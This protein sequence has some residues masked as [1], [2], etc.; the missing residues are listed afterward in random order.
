METLPAFDIPTI[1]SPPCA[2]L[3]APLP[4]GLGTPQVE[5]LTSYL[6]RVARLHQVRLG[7]LG[8]ELIRPLVWSLRA[9]YRRGR[10]AAAFQRRSV[11]FGKLFGAGPEATL[12]V[13][14]SEQLTGRADLRYLTLLRTRHAI[15]DA[16][17]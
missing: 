9:D 15:N 5:H 17:S 8:R 4:Y 3:L 10:F 2:T 11:P 14:A 7:H 1:K 16:M 6:H 12:W 13:W